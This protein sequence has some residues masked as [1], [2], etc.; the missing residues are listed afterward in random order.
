MTKED[1]QN[2]NEL[3]QKSLVNLADQ[4]VAETKEMLRESQTEEDLRVRF[5]RFLDPIKKELGIDIKDTNE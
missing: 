5:E 2:N 4:L 3:S 1:M